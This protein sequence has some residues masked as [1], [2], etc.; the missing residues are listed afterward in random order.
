[1]KKLICALALTLSSCA[2]M[3]SRPSDDPSPA[4]FK[5]SQDVLQVDLSSLWSRGQGSQ[6]RYTHRKHGYFRIREAD[7]RPLNEHWQEWGA[8]LQQPKGLDSFLG[9]IQRQFPS[10]TAARQP[11][12]LEAIQKKDRPWLQKWLK[13]QEAVWQEQDMLKFLPLRLQLGDLHWYADGPLQPTRLEG[14]AAYAGAICSSGSFG[15]GIFIPRG[16]KLIFLDTSRPRKKED[17]E[18]AADWPKRL[19]FGVEV[20]PSLLDQPP[21][22]APLPTSQLQT[23]AQRREQQR[24]ARRK[25]DWLKPIAPLLP[26]LFALI[27]GYFVSLPARLG[28]L[29][30]Y[31]DYQERGQNPRVGAAMWA[32]SY[33]FK[34]LGW[35]VA[36][37]LLLMCALAAIYNT[38]S[39][40][41]SLFLAAIVLSI[42]VLLFSVVALLT[43]SASAAVGAYLGAGISREMA[44]RLAALGV[45]LGFLLSPLVAKVAYSGDHHRSRKRHR[46][47]QEFRPQGLLGINQEAF[48]QQPNLPNRIRGTREGLPGTHTSV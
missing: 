25:N 5:T 7:L 11:D 10:W 32:A 41:M 24:A 1:M 2:P 9:Q 29:G 21:T 42:A 6:F 14:Q 30:G 4:Y 36:V 26:W 35:L 3:P 16:S 39:G 37:S 38:N 18:W 43:A 34:S 20:D 23:R 28:A 13:Q 15:Y 48:R 45:I 47:S 12:V 33:T 19:H 27:V 44:A 40:I 17:Q 22:P 8:L 46:H 31:D